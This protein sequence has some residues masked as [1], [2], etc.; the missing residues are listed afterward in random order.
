VD[1]IAH[2]DQLTQ[3][4][5]R[6]NMEGRLEKKYQQYRLINQPFSIL[7]ADLDN[8]KFINDRYGHDVGDDILYAIGQVLSEPLRGEDI[9]AR[10]GGNEF[11][12]LLP[13]A[14]SEAAVNIAERLRAAA[15][16]LDMDAQGDKLRISLS[17]GVA[18]IDKCTG[19]DDLLSTAEN[20]LYQ[21][22]HMG[23]D[24]VVVG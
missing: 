7:L 5:N 9:V 11:M 21:A 19:I 6:N 22:K 12:V 3:L 14:N 15:S 13:T 10:W 18:S 20:G 4:P 1:Q 17:V 8:F 23:R 2:Q 16:E 24:M